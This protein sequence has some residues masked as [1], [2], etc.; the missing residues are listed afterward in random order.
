MLLH[1]ASRLWLAVLGPAA[2]FS[3][4]LSPSG[5]H[6][7]GVEWYGRVVAQ[8]TLEGIEGAR[9]T[10]EAVEAEGLPDDTASPPGT[11]AQ[12]PEARLTTADG[13]FSTTAP[14]GVRLRISAPGFLDGFVDLRP[15][16]DRDLGRLVLRHEMSFSGR[17]VRG[18]Q[19]VPAV[20]VLAPAGREYGIR[21]S[22]PP[23]AVSDAAGRFYLRNLRP[24]QL[25]EL[26]VISRGTA[27]S[28]DFGFSGRPFD[29]RHY[30]LGDIELLALHTLSG[31][32][33]DPSGGAAAN[34]PVRV[35]RSS[36]LRLSS[37]GNGS[38]AEDSIPTPEA[39]T[40][41][42]GR[43]ELALPAGEHTLIVL[44]GASG[45]A[46]VIANMDRPGTSV[47]L[48]TIV[49]PG[50]VSR[51]GR[52][53]SPEGTPLP[54]VTVALA[55]VS[56][57]QSGTYDDPTLRAPGTRTLTDAR[58]C[59]L[60]AGLPAAEAVRIQTALD[61]FVTRRIRV[62]A[63]GSMADSDTPGAGECDR[64]GDLGTASLEIAGR[65]GGTV[66][67]QDGRPIPGVDLS[68]KHHLIP[69]GPHGPTSPATVS[70]DR[71]RFEIDRLPQG[72]Y[73]VT[74]RSAGHLATFVRSVA[75]GLVDTSPSDSGSREQ[76]PVAPAQTTGGVAGE[77][78][79]TLRI[80]MAEIENLVPLD[81][82]VLDPRG[83]PEPEAEVRASLNTGNGLTPVLARR[84]TG[85]DGRVLFDTAAAGVYSIVATAHGR[86]NN[87]Y[88]QSPFRVQE[89]MMPAV[90]EMQPITAPFVSLSGRFV[91]Q[92]GRGIP[93]AL[94]HARG[95][96]RRLRDTE[97]LTEADGS[98]R[99]D[100]IP[101]GRYVLKATAPGLP[102]VIHRNLLTIDP[103]GIDNLVIEVPPLATIVGSIAG[104]RDGEGEYL[105]VRA[106]TEEVH[107]ENIRQSSGVEGE[108][109]A[110]GNFRIDD[111]I[112]GNWTVSARASGGRDGAAE[113]L[114]DGS[115]DTA[116]VTVSMFT[117]FTL[118]GSVVWRED[119]PESAR[120]DISGVG[121]RERRV[122]LFD[123][124]DRF[125][126]HDLPAGEYR[127]VVGDPSLRRAVRSFVDVR[128]DTDIEIVVRGAS[129]TGRV[130][131]AADG[132]PIAGVGISAHPIPQIMAGGPA[133]NS[134]RFGGF[135]FGPFAAGPW[136][137]RFHAAGYASRAPLIEIGDQDIIDL[138]ITMRRTPGLRLRFE[139][140]DGA[141]PAII[142]LAWY[143]LDHGEGFQH[144]AFPE[145][146]DSI[147]VSLAGRR[148]DPRH[149]VR[150]K[151]RHPARRTPGDHQRRAT[152]RCPAARRRKAVCRRPGPP[153]E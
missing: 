151:R 33:V 23:E 67:D 55:S 152:G 32:V 147:G 35:Y 11:D 129:V 6:A 51:G 12:D 14:P 141:P 136:R 30:E 78:D 66:V 46:L 80:V 8:S 27:Q 40:G 123:P 96:V 74:A 97:A 54:G 124:L 18:D 79:V 100:R 58:G 19:P 119:P 98:F 76:P 117:G 142:S 20:R 9:I 144:A 109:D 91:D 116:R 53:V 88:W 84:F 99:F 82:L 121:L 1:R 75:V 137:F 7:Q 56:S 153:G 25:T 61:G 59:Y 83:A 105:S 143:D 28:I 48:G 49:L 148:A 89:G 131:D 68:A 39:P 106:Q 128:E 65:I 5:T 37:P 73:T 21:A 26:V 24:E 29:A 107:E 13:G 38:G 135:A 57:W 34:A 138:P 72:D 62:E 87:S 42:D 64:L 81:I 111:L 110:V 113:V 4:T 133:Q 85:A 77:L 150:V 132:A 95:S 45:N 41:A 118:T 69:G 101:A 146:T 112:P 10:S 3:L 50:T 31:R 120:L 102:D 17:I 114:L 130:V 63:D 60:L 127:I 47:D 108:V 43:F 125:E 52:I 115:G 93:R 134:D 2:L 140:P 92:D 16:R 139:T 126:V 103:P 70:D 90:V 22:P 145:M 36:S 149:P 15:G 94:I 122:V 104:L 44:G 86:R 71:G